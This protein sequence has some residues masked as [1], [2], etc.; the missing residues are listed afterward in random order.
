M[1]VPCEATYSNF[2]A[3]TVMLGIGIF[4]MYRGMRQQGC[5]EGGEGEGEK[6]DTLHMLSIDSNP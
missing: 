1:E 6:E 2:K 5:K 4:G 3:I